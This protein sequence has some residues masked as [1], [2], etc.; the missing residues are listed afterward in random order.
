MRDIFAYC[1]VLG[2]N[3]PIPSPSKV[4]PTPVITP[5]IHIPVPNL[6]VTPEPK[7]QSSGLLFDPSI[8]ES[9]GN[10]G[11]LNVPVL[12][13]VAPMAVPVTTAGNSTPPGSLTRSDSLAAVI[14]DLNKTLSKSTVGKDT[15]GKIKIIQMK[16]S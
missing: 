3:F 16:F 9:F 12:S 15:I 5:L 4:T 2:K 7:T 8:V 14:A 11:I 1:H 10:V 13:P 6:P